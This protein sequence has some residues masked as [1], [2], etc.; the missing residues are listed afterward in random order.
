MNIDKSTENYEMDQ[1]CFIAWSPLEKNDFSFKHRYITCSRSVPHKSKRLAKYRLSR[2]LNF[3]ASACNS[4][5]ENSSFEEDKHLSRSAKIMRALNFNS[6][7]SY[8]GKTKIKKSLNF[9]LTPSP[10]SFRHAKKG[11]RKSLSLNFSSPLS[12]PNKFLNLNDNP[13]ESANSTL[14]FSSSDSIDEN[15]NETPL[16]QSTKEHEMLHYSTPNAKYTRKSSCHSASFTPLLRSRLKETI[17]NIVY[18]AATP[19]SQSLKRVKG[20]TKYTNNITMNTSRNLLHEFHDKDD[21][22]S[23]TPKNLICIIPESMSAIKRSHKKERSSRR[24]DG[25][26]TQFTDSF[27]KNESVLQ[28]RFSQYSKQIDQFQDSRSDIEQ[29]ANRSSNELVL[30]HSEDDMSDTGSLFDYTEEQKHIFEESKK[31]SEWKSNYT[32]VIPKID[33]FDVKVKLEESADSFSRADTP[34]RSN[35]D[36]SNL[37]NENID[38]AG[39]SVTPEPVKETVSESQKSVTPE[40][41]INILQTI[42]KDSIKKS[43]KKIK[44]NNKRRLFSPKVLQD[45]LD[46]MEKQENAKCSENFEQYES[47]EENKISVEVNNPDVS[48]DERSSTPDK[49]S[50]SRLLLS[51]FSSVKK[52]HKKDKHN[53]ILCGFLKRQEYFNK[54]MDLVTNNKYEQRTFNDEISECKN[55]IEDFPSDL[56]VVRNIEDSTSL[57]ASASLSSSLDKLSPSK[58]KKPQN[59][60]LDHEKNVSYD[61]EL[62]ELDTS[63]EEFKIFTPLKRKRS[64]FAFTV[65]KEYTHFYDLASEKNERSDDTVGSISFSRCLTPVL[66]FPNSCVKVEKDDI[67]TKSDDNADNGNVEEVYDSNCDSNDVTGRLTPRNMSTTELYPNLDSI[68]KSHKK[69]KRGNSSRKMFNAMKNNHSIDE[70]HE[71]SLESVANEMYNP[72]EFS[73]DCVIADDVINKPMY[74]KSVNN[75][76]NLMNHTTDDN[77]NCPSTSAE[78]ISTTVTPPNYL[79]TKAYMKLLQETSIKRSHKKNRNKRKQELVVDTNELS[80]DGSIFGD[81]EKSCFIEDRSAH[82]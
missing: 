9:N 68:K 52:S 71:T 78:N 51:Q 4:N 82:D 57:V 48:R 56:D 14:L 37:C 73:N 46:A 67:I 26:T 3:D 20:R 77:Q 13:S 63:K 29:C 22:R 21:N 23:C 28:D 15:Q 36:A 16:Q 69:N 32:S 17:D 76:E 33:K 44:D 24:S 66:N 12:V 30:S 64:L 10:K 50:S 55:S 35:M 6:S 18:V 42:S 27:V 80:D 62:Q 61:F 41:R 2:S 1:K 75:V 11:I 31:V 49:V 54:D 38:L 53:K 39:R 7:P 60:P 25:Y 47:T 72:L 58:R 19:N 5:S 81:E 8:Y 70:K 65:A 74:D 43:H 34:D 59:I 45:K 79:K 40:N